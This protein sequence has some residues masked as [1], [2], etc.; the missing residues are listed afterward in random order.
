ML[1]TPEK[2]TVVRQEFEH[3]LEQGIV[4]S[5]SSQ[6]SSLFHIVPKKFPGDWRP[7]GDYC[8]LNQITIPDCYPI[9]HM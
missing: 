7:C 4:R 1:T 2:L 3:M 6:W 8:A 5:S 9:P